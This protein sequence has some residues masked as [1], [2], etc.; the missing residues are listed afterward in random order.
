MSVKKNEGRQKW[1]DQERLASNTQHGLQD[2]WDGEFLANHPEFRRPRRK[3]ESADDETGDVLRGR[4]AESD[5][6]VAFVEEWSRGLEVPRVDEEVAFGAK[7][8]VQAKLEGM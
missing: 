8:G 4:H 7:G 1:K 2:L 6:V 3:A 5:L